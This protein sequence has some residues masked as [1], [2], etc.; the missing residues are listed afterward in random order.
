MTE[1]L[2]PLCVVVALGVRFVLGRRAGS[3]HSPPWMEVR[4]PMPLFFVSSRRVPLG[5][6][7]RLDESKVERASS[8]ARVGVSYGPIVLV[9]VFCLPPLISSFAPPIIIVCLGPTLTCSMEDDLCPTLLDVD[10]P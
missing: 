6:R 5:R 4:I 1:F 8:S 2:L 9:F 10:A 7:R 3:L